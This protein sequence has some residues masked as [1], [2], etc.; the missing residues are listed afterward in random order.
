MN[1]KSIGRFCWFWLFFGDS[2]KIF[3]ANQKILSPWR[4]N[5]HKKTLV[6]TVFLTQQRAR[7]C[8][9]HNSSQ[10][11]LSEEFEHKKYMLMMFLTLFLKVD[12][13][14]YAKNIDIC[15]YS[16]DFCISWLNRFLHFLKPI[17]CVSKKFLSKMTKIAK[18]QPNIWSHEKNK[19][20]PLFNIKN[21]ATFQESVKK[22]LIAI[23]LCICCC[24]W[25]ATRQASSA[26]IA[27]K[28]PVSISDIIAHEIA[29]TIKG[30]VT[31]IAVVNNL[32]GGTSKSQQKLQWCPLLRR[33]NAVHQVSAEIGLGACKPG[34]IGAPVPGWA[35]KIRQCKK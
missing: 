14:F 5:W 8:C 10:E 29:H 17:E 27:P 18:N 28:F 13:F 35:S 1:E 34:Q 20:G 16:F 21:E 26:Y 24:C 25:Y 11:W 23:G 12:Q 19:H 7:S 22:W 32:K 33:K 4:W 9:C 2:L 6:I 3:I 15:F 30:G 31:S